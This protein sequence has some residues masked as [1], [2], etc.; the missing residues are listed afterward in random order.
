MIQIRVAL[1]VAMMETLVYTRIWT[2]HILVMKWS[3][4]AVAL[5]MSNDKLNACISKVEIPVMEY[6]ELFN[7]IR[8]SE[9]MWATLESSMKDLDDDEAWTG[10][11]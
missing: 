5:G 9:D 8:Q 2:D 11:N 10:V 1:L 7:L 4:V 6:V 3:D